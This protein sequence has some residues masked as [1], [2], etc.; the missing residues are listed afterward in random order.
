[1]VRSLQNN[2]NQFNY[3]KVYNL[4]LREQV[5]FTKIAKTIPK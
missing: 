5:D 1:M 2:D 3:L 4:N